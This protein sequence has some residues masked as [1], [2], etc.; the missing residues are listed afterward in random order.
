[1]ARALGEREYGDRKLKQAAN[2]IRSNPDR[3]VS[4]CARRYVLFWLPAWDQFPFAP[5]VWLA[6]ALAFPALL[7]SLRSESRLPA[8]LAA[9]AIAYSLVYALVGP[10]L[11]YCEPILWVT[12]LFAKKT[13]LQFWPNR[14]STV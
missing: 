6:K 5:V 11:R 7:Y 8:L 14:Q 12:M 2:W 1:L 4:L 10:E 3:F 9:S 13:A